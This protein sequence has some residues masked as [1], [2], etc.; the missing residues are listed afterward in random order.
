MAIDPAMAVNALQ[1]GSGIATAG[2][3]G[4]VFGLDGASPADGAGFSGTSASKGGG[5]EDALQA[6]D[7]AEGQE[8]KAAQLESAFARG[9]D[10]PLHEVMAAA[11]EASLSVETLA[12]LRNRLVD[13]LNELTRIQA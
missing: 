1:G 6:L 4:R 5:F 9:E 10:V 3:A 7:N 2:Q 8:R 12:A 11:E 13:A